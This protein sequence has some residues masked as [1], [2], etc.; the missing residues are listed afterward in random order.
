LRASQLASTLLEFVRKIRPGA[1][2]HV[3]LVLRRGAF[4]VPPMQ[5]RG[6]RQ[7]VK[8]HFH[9]VPCSGCVSVGYTDEENP[10]QTLETH[11]HARTR[12][13]VCVH[14]RAHAPL[15]FWRSTEV[16]L[17][18]WHACERRRT[19]CVCARTHARIAETPTAF[20]AFR[21]MVG[22]SIARMHACTYARMHACTHARMRA[23]RVSPGSAGST[24]QVSYSS[25]T[26]ADSAHS[27]ASP[28]MFHARACHGAPTRDAPT[29][30]PQ[31]PAGTNLHQ[32]HRR[33]VVPSA[34]AAAARRPLVALRTVR[35]R[36]MRACRS[37]AF[38]HL[39]PA[40]AALD[41]RVRHAP[42]HRRRH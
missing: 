24:C 23:R 12:K 29:R 39:L 8:G 7:D 35:A 2:H 4:A 26:V 11:A 33:L 30:V 10:G 31:D 16:G 20:H 6:L 25:I 14:A 13:R 18:R 19:A 3:E 9:R 36:V 38:V 28:C 5:R 41:G 42:G 1:I 32:P 22:W 40:H 17:C 34:V 15:M 27:S 21:F 37:R